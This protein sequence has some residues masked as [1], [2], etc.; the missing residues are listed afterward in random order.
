MR[1]TCPMHTNIPPYLVLLFVDFNFIF[2]KE[3]KQIFFLTMH[4]YFFFLNFR[5]SIKRLTCLAYPGN[6]ALH[7]RITWA[8]A[9]RSDQRQTS[10][11]YQTIGERKIRQGASNSFS[12]LSFHLLSPLLLYFLL[13]CIQV[14]THSA[15]HVWQTAISRVQ[16]KAAS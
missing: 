6:R 3:K 14:S 16:Q 13:L 4:F 11:F 7:G 5:A 10:K 8:S 2:L 12:F 1:G 15:V 9:R